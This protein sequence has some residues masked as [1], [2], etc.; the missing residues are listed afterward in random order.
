[1]TI[2]ARK[3]LKNPLLEI[4]INKKLI[5]Q[6]KQHSTLLKKTFESRNWRQNFLL[7]SRDNRQYHAGQLCR[8]KRTFFSLKETKEQSIKTSSLSLK[9]LQKRRKEQVLE[10]RKLQT[11]LRKILCPIS[12][13]K[14]KKS[15]HYRKTSLCLWTKPGKR[16]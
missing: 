4:K 9:Q 3:P 6:R 1:M 5:S 16:K 10:C 15:L 8:I 13:P 14:M 7:N 12:Y 11:F 2:L